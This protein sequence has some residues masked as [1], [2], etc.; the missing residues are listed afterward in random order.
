MTLFAP[1]IGKRININSAQ[2]ASGSDTTLVT[3]KAQAPQTLESLMVSANGAATFSLW[4]NDGTTD[5]YIYRAKSVA[6]ND[7]LFLQNHNIIIP[8]GWTLKCRAGT[9]NSLDVTG[10][11]LLSSSIQNLPTNYSGI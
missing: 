10:T 3:G 7:V 6:A 4:L 1:S 11:L 9:A 5:Y 8:E 2:I